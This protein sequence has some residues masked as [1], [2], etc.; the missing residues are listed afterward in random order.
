MMASKGIAG[1]I[2]NMG[3]IYG[4]VASGNIIGYNASKGAVEM[5]TKAAAL[6]LA[7]YNIRVVAIAP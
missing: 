5:M 7:P 6:E 3:S 2:I 1:V 4:K